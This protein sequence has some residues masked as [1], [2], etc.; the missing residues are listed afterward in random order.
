M[1]IEFS[2]HA[3]VQLVNRP[4]VKREM[5]LETINLPDAVTVSYR[6][7][8]LYRKR[9]GAETLEVVTVNEG[10]TIIVVTQY[11]LDES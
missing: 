5:I 2:D 4:R 3:M 9:F 6:Q 10:D 7:R 1:K 8:N 11:F